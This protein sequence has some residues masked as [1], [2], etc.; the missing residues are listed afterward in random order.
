MN[1]R[2]RIYLRT[3]ELIYS[4][5]IRVGVPFGFVRFLIKLCDAVFSPEDFFRRYFLAR[6][7]TKNSKWRNFIP[8]D[9]GY[10]TFASGEL[11]FFEPLEQA[12]RKIYETK[13][14]ELEK[15]LP[16]PHYD[17]IHYNDLIDPQ[18]FKEYPEL[19]EA[20]TS[21]EIV[22]ILSDYFGGVP[23]LQGIHIWL[24]T[25]GMVDDEIHQIN[26]RIYERKE[27]SDVHLDK[28]E[29]GLV[30][31]FIINNLFSFFDNCKL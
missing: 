28:L 31:L 13:V 12:A 8:R 9:K 5:G 6:K 10:A 18:D 25:P 26:G 20:A 22:A 30:Y 24:S 14:K 7:I 21:P 29:E 17:D 3:R 27:A 19:L 15:R 2:E 23:R 1:L 11:S 16:E 4:Y